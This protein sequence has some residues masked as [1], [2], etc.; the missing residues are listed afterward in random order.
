MS[1][2]EL[3]RWRTLSITFNLEDAMYRIIQAV[4]RQSSR[5]SKLSRLQ[6]ICTAR[7]ELLIPSTRLARQDHENL[8]SQIGTL[9]LDAVY[10]EPSSSL[11]DNLTHLTI[12]LRFRSR[13]TITSEH[14]EMIFQKSPR[15]V[16]LELGSIYFSIMIDNPLPGSTPPIMLPYLEDLFLLAIEFC[17]LEHL[18]QLVSAPALKRLRHPQSKHEAYQGCHLLLLLRR[19][20]RHQHNEVRHCRR[21]RI[22]HTQPHD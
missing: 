15:L 9:R 4:V 20:Q 10:V 1:M 3:P 12:F 14:L 16:T 11:Y 7:R 21:R 6:L 13:I 2:S 18:L 5:C 17:T 8:F 22:L 19:D